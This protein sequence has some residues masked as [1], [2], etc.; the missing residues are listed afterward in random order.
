M[1]SD[2]E[3]ILDYLVKTD[4]GD[5]NLTIIKKF[6]YPNTKS[7][8]LTFVHKNTQQVGCFSDKSV[9]I[10]ELWLKDPIS[11]RAD[12]YTVLLGGLQK[13]CVEIT[14]T[15]PNNIR[16]DIRERLN[17]DYGVAT[18]QHIN[19][20]KQCNIDGTLPEGT[21]TKHM[22]MTAMYIVYHTFHW[23]NRFKLRDFSYKDCMDGDKSTA[24]SVLRM[25][26][27][28]HGKTWY[29]K[30]F[31]AKLSGKNYEQ[32][33]SGVR[34]LEIPSEKIPWDDF[35]TI[36]KNKLTRNKEVVEAVYKR[37]DT[38]KA[39]FSEL[40]KSLSK[41][42]LCLTIQPWL[43]DFVDY[44]LG[45][46]IESLG[47]WSI[48][49]KKLENDEYRPIRLEPYKTKAPNYLYNNYKEFLKTRVV[50]GGYQFF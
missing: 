2:N 4:K 12:S 26:L 5:Y 31:N 44:V 47:D 32:Y 13:G 33:I 40:S 38:Y 11:L 46:Y 15:N 19:T 3:A 17:I 35:N 8:I 41:T 39:F 24:F 25:S 1:S 21:G 37:T 50:R 10:D 49:G 43:N 16:P 30:T 29:E 27:V 9:T 18:I 45:F 48:D 14:F 23:I 28:L 7:N 42:E 20:G 36:I 6:S 22:V 34:K